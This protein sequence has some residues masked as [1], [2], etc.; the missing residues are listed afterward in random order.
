MMSNDAETLKIVCL[1][2]LSSITTPKLVIADLIISN[3]KAIV[4]KWLNAFVDL[5]VAT[6][7]LFILLI[8]FLLLNLVLFCIWCRF[9]LKI[10]P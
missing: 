7:A 3:S 4:S 5:T 1:L 8:I 6:Y 2:L 9:A 10:D